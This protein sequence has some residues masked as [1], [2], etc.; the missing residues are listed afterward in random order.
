MKQKANVKALNVEQKAA[1][2]VGSNFW[3]T[4]AI[5]EAGFP[6]LFLCDGPHGLRKQD[7]A[8]SDHLGLNESAVSVCYPTG[9]AAA[10]S[11]DTELLRFMG[12]MLGREA[13][14]SGVDVLLGP[15][16]NIKRSP[17]CGRNFEYYS[18]DP[19]LAGELAAAF[20]QGVQR[21][22]VAAC[23]KHF[24]ANNQETRRKAVDA[25][26]DE[27][28]LREIY[29]APFE[30]AV[31]QGGAWA[32]MS[33]YNKVNGAYPAQNPHLVKEILRGEWGFRGVL[34]TDWG[35]M[36]QIVP[37]LQAGLTL[38]MP[39]S[40]GSA[41]EKLVR[42]VR[43]GELEEAELDRAAGE[44]AYLA[45]RTRRAQRPQADPETCHAAALRVALGSMV[46]LKNQGGLLPLKKGVRLAVV[47]QM[48]AEPR[49]QGAG[50]SHVNPY[51]L[52][53]ALEELKK[54]WPEL[55]YAP[56][57]EGESMSAAQLEEARQA[58]A[59]AGATLLFV[60]LPASYEAETY[61]REALDLP[62]AH[63]RLVRE[64]ARAT[65]NLAVVLCGGAAVRMPWRRAPRAIL[66][67]YLGGE[68]GGEAVAALVAGHANPSGKLAETFPR[69][70]EHTP[71]YLNWPGEGD[72]AE[73]REG[74]FV[75]YRYYEKK[76]L[77]PAFPFG[78]GLSY[79]R[80]SYSGLALSA[81]QLEEGGELTVRCTVQ[82]TGTMA[83]AEV[84]QLYVEN[85]P[86]PRA[87]PL[88]ELRGFQKLY[89]APGEKACAEFRLGRR[90]FSYYEPELRDWYAPQGDYGILV[91]A[92]SANIRLR[93]RVQCT[94]VRRV[95]RPV[96]RNTLLGDILARPE[97]EQA[98]LPTYKAIRPYL[99][100]GLDRMDLAQDRMARSL[101]ENMTLNSLAGYVGRALDDAVLQE[102]IARLNEAQARE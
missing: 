84:V 74:V 68:A 29:L 85:P 97:L 56:G 101:L 39:G 81:R 12:E 13:A 80:F 17:L 23:P 32:V 1:L 35:A 45:G 52:T 41:A 89:L 58:A 27:R 42:A 3:M 44:L 48:A 22:G 4:R 96:G 90:A 60:G 100:F 10:C 43:A 82:N 78:H 98:L 57:Y 59:G 55:T 76:K 70:L 28:T 71:A 93:G 61:D 94:A 11:W 26:M 7:V 83:G 51:R 19:Y 5:P 77:R 40:D 62:P 50:S 8:H 64:L 66:E 34:V 20:V 102:L 75:G 73:Y 95:R 25:V 18:E 37:S 72:R 24:A 38:Q 99:P 54:E 65:P 67:A 2:C 87:R 69:R 30:A 88:K 49:Y 9:A 91:G 46:L 86:G 14:Q 92:S 53:S 15:A 47:G 6:A 79:T 33:S 16:I 21:N 31:R 36:D 63:D